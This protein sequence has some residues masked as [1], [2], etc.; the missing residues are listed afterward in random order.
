MPTAVHVSNRPAVL[1][2]N[3]MD[4][5]RANRLP[6]AK[7]RPHLNTPNVCVVFSARHCPVHAALR[8]DLYVAHV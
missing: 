3:S 5:E 4:N 1:F 6:L 2:G 7:P 8:R